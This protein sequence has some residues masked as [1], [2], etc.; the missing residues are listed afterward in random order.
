MASDGFCPRCDVV[1]EDI[2]HLIRGYKCS[3][4]VWDSLP[5]CRPTTIVSTGDILDCLMSNLCNGGQVE[6]ASCVDLSRSDYVEMGGKFFVVKI[7]DE[8]F[9]IEKQEELRGIIP[10]GRAGTL[11]PVEGGSVVENS[12]DVRRL[13]VDGDKATHE[14][15]YERV[16]VSVSPITLKP[17]FENLAEMV[18]INNK[19]SGSLGENYATTDKF[20]EGVSGQERGK[21]PSK[22]KARDEVV[23]VG[24]MTEISSVVM[25]GAPVGVK[26]VL[27][28]TPGLFQVEGSVPGSGSKS[29]R[30]RL[31][32]HS[33]TLRSKQNSELRNLEDDVA[34]V[35]EKGLALGLN[36]NGR[37][38]ELLDIIAK[39]DVMNDNRFRDLVRRL[40]LTYK[41]KG[42]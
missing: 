41:A 35:L 39:R 17:N 40:V 12:E 16:G 37:K 2:D 27:S 6:G 28:G 32:K 24:P 26:E 38:E 14:D 8:Q 31:K 29:I 25:G 22:E 19:R 36:F 30:G 4:M 34:K 11:I 15:S 21:G 33:M 20:F 23:I 7:E 13:S 10:V 1:N 9:S 18:G 5:T 3:M 42:C